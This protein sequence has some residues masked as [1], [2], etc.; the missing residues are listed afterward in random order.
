M[1][2]TTNAKVNPLYTTADRFNAV[3]HRD[4]F[5]NDWQRGRDVSKFINVNTIEMFLEAIAI[6]MEIIL[7]IVFQ[8]YL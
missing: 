5:L 8:F 2:R 1:R 6:P 3:V 4:A 7:L